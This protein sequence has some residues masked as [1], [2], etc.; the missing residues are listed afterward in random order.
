MRR[1]VPLSY[2]YAEKAAVIEAACLGFSA[3]G[4]SAGCAWSAE[5]IKDSLGREDFC[6]IG[7]FEDGVLA[8]VC[9]YY[10]VIDELQIVNLAV[11]PEFRRK[12]IGRAMI[13]Y[14]KFD[15]R[16]Q[17]CKKILLE[18]EKGNLAAAALYESVGFVCVGERKG[19][20]GCSDAVLADYT[21][22]A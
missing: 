15:A 20:Y 19:F 10:I 2:Q 14:I 21:V 22:S 17:D 3:Y 4:T 18:Y 9:S 8:A 13:D 7:V 11:L 5:Q 16:I 6:Y 1:I 12:G